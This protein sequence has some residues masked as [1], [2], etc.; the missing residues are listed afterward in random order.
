MSE[1]N[2]E[3]EAD[4]EKDRDKTDEKRIDAEDERIADLWKTMNEKLDLISQQT[5]EALQTS[6]AAME[7]VTEAQQKKIEEA[8]TQTAESQAEPLE[9][10]GADPEETLEAIVPDMSTSQTLE[11]EPSRQRMVRTI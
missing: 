4:L 9:K 5:A 1:E 11:K 7:K 10:S 2:A 3:H 6:R 8:L